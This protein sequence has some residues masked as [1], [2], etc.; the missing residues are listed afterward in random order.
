M[1]PA[2]PDGKPLG[3]ATFPETSVEPTA[4]PGSRYNDPTLH[5]GYYGFEAPRGAPTNETRHRDDPGQPTGHPHREQDTLK[6]APSSDPTDSTAQ[7]TH[8]AP[9]R[10]QHHTTLPPSSDQLASPTTVPDCTRALSTHGTLR[11]LPDHASKRRT[12]SLYRLQI[13]AHR[14]GPGAAGAGQAPGDPR[15]Q[16]RRRYPEAPSSTTPNPP[17]ASTP[18]PAH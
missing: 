17:G 16:P 15:P 12:H 9:D 7:R 8:R 14:A 4:I 5:R 13:L 2:P 1:N 6:Q 18:R 3:V 10:S 11:P